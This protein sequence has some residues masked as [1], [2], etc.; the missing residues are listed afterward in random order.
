ML[1]S[2][3]TLLILKTSLRFY[4]N[5]HESTF[6]S[7]TEFPNKKRNSTYNPVFTAPLLSAIPSRQFFSLYNLNRD[8][9]SLIL[10]S[11]ENR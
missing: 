6:C 11:A 5:L 4:Y 1:L 8:F 2:S 3:Y 10:E 9:S 7:V